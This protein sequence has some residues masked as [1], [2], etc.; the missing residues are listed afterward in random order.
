MRRDFSLP[1]VD[2]DFLIASGF[3]WETWND[4][5]GMWLI[6]KNYSIPN[7]YTVS[8]SDLALKIDPGYPV[9]QIDMV[10]FSNELK[11]TGKTIG[12]LADRKSVV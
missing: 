6:I 8:Q 4:G 2:E 12:A 11:I 3:V 9:S 7:G 5:A 10:Y 1:E